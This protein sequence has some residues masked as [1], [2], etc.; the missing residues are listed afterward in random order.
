MWEKNTFKVNQIGSTTSHYINNTKV[1][2]H[3]DEA[4]TSGGYGFYSQKGIQA[5]FDNFKA[6]TKQT[7]IQQR[8]VY[9]TIDEASYDI[10]P[11]IYRGQI[12]KCIALR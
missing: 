10:S 8:G 11:R 1:Y 9:I 3:N 5:A 12:G 7:D 2:T 4:F 6:I